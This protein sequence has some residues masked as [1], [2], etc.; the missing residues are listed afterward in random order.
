M[1]DSTAKLGVPFPLPEDAL[2]DYP[3]LGS[4]LAAKIDDLADFH[5]LWDS[6]DAGV[7]LPVAQITTP[8]LPATFK[9]LL[10]AW[11]AKTAYGSGGDL[12]GVRF[13]NNATAS[14]YDQWLRAAGTAVSAGSDNTATG[15]RV[16]DMAG[17]GS[18]PE[19]LGSGLLLVPGY[20]TS[21]IFQP[22]V[23][24]AGGAG[25]IVAGG[26]YNGLSYGFWGGNPAV[27]LLTF[28]SLNGGAFQATSRFT[29]WGLG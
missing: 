1:P 24:L 19:G 22:A 25:A 16:G 2:V 28:Y 17:G 12:L 14:Y 18:R 27:S 21:G 7:V 10:V 8:T 29:V 23:A 3:A 15:W 13:N 6:V 5:L 9:H 26:N 11:T 4:A 20:S